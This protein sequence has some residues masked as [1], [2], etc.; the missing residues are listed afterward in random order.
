MRQTSTHNA[1]KHRKSKEHISSTGVGNLSSK[2][3]FRR[4]A[5]NV[6]YLFRLQDTISKEGDTHMSHFSVAVIS[7][8]PEDVDSLLE[9]FWEDLDKNS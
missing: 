6:K 8:K 1:A 5:H 7:K 2:G 3:T 9:H 4:G